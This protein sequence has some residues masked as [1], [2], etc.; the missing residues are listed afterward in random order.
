MTI[1]YNFHGRNSESQ[2]LSYSTSAAIECSTVVIQIPS[3]LSHTVIELL[4]K[5]IC[6]VSIL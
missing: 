4:N 5:L 3:N 1:E 6:P 2:A